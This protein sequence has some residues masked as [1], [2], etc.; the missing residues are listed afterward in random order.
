MWRNTCGTF[1]LIIL[2]VALGGCS[3]LIIHANDDWGH[4][5]A[6]TEHAARGL[7]LLGPAPHLER[8]KAKGRQVPIPK[9]NQIEVGPLWA[10]ISICKGGLL[11]EGVSLSE[12]PSLAVTFFVY[13][14]LVIMISQGKNWA[15]NI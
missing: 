1:S 3:S 4:P 15:R 11:L 14:F 2:F 10:T 5:Y 7:P 12:V 9:R 13:V 6:A 8:L